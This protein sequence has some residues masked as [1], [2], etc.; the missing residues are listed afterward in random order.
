MLNFVIYSALLFQV[1]TGCRNNEAAW[2]VNTHHSVK[3]N[4]YVLWKLDYPY[5]AT[6]PYEQ[7]KT[8]K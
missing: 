7:T 5:V 3:P 4:P 8:A 1:I 6:M 2:I